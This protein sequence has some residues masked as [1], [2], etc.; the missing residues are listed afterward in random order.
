MTLV[1]DRVADSRTQQLKALIE[2]LVDV[3]KAHGGTVSQ[4]EAM[5][6]AAT[7]AEMSVSEMPYIVN[8]AVA[9]HRITADLRSG[10]LKLVV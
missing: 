7:N 2:I 1:A 5:R 3:V 6:E 4:R 9:D 10:K 8:S